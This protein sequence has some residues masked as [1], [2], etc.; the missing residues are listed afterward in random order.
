MSKFTKTVRRTF[1]CEGDEVVVVLKRLKRKD[2]M[3]LM[4][5]MKSEADGE[6]IG[7]MDSLE[8]LDF[9]ADLLPDYIV[10]MTGL[11]DED[12]KELEFSDIAGEAYFMTLLSEIC[13]AL[14]E[15]SNM[16]GDD[17]KNSQRQSTT[18]ASTP[19]PAED[20]PSESLHVKVGSPSSSDAEG[21]SN[22][23]GLTGEPT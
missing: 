1:T 12:G 7:A 2:M 23:A 10:S 11:L 9:S 16:Q 14:F 8:M 3:R 15:A 13:M 18:S 17:S 19:E 20:I 21:E 5:Y 22:G 4:P 6:A